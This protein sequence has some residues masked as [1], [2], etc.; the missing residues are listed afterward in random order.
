MFFFAIKLG[1]WI[2]RKNNGGEVTFPSPAAAG[3]GGVVADSTFPGNADLDRKGASAGCLH[4]ELVSV[5]LFHPLFLGRKPLS[6]AHSK[7]GR[8]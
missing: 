7:G 6:V 2:L 5:F 1:S 4:V 3:G 8:N